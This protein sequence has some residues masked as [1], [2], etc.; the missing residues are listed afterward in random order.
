MRLRRAL[1][2]LL[3]VTLLASLPGVRIAPAQ[4][5]TKYDVKTESFNVKT[6]YGDVYV[7]VQR[8]VDPKNPKRVVK[9]PAILTYSPYS[10]L[11]VG[12]CGDRICDTNRWVP[13]GYARVWADVIGT[14]NSGGC[15][16][17]GGTA[18]KVSGYDL[19]EAIAKQPWSDGK[20]A[21]IGGSYEGTTAWATAVMHPPHLTTIVPEA[22]IARWYD[23]AFAG[24]IRYNDNNEAP[25]EGPAA[26]S[27]EGIDTPAG[28]DFG[29]AVPP[30]VDNQDP[31][32]AHKFQQHVTPCQQL[33]HTQQGYSQTPDYGKFW[34][35]RDYLLD[36]G[37]IHI[38]VMISAN[39]G[40]WNVKQIES[41]DMYHAIQNS[42]KKV[43]FMGN[44]WSGHGVPGGAYEKTV[45]AWMDHWL[46]GK[47]NG[48]Q[49]LP[50]VISQTSDL[51]QKYTWEQG[52]W[53][54]VTNVVLYA[55]ETPVTNPNDYAWK[56]LPTPWHKIKG[57]PQPQD[58]AKWPSANA[59]TESHEA[60]HSRTNHDWFWFE[61]PMLKHSIRVFGSPVVQV[62]LQTARSWVTV[63]PALFDE[64]IS[65]MQMEAGQMVSMDPVMLSAVT[66]GWLDSRYRDGLSKQVPLRVN[67]PFQL[68]VPL[69]P[70][71]WTFQK[72]HFLGLGLSTEIDEWSIPKPYP[73]PAEGAN[74]ANCTFVKIDWQHA[75]T[76]LILPV[77]G[78]VKN[79]M[80]LFDF[81][82]M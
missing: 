72:M 36:A 7:E 41:I 54:Q 2:P 3:A 12:L 43:L 60:H 6:K 18:E 76:R 16:D 22:A 39:W 52:A 14:G 19:V 51:N 45:N 5:A 35:Q 40:D 28:F 4:A 77:V 81:R 53:P 8:P 31:D 57:V 68:S 66:R 74:A 42:Q 29:L 15:W 9:A 47:D 48:V 24:G 82:G 33:E 65:R 63:T 1:V 78:T 13:R 23:Y 38:P 25:R 71:D 58:T 80:S 37:S 10:I 70:T 44:A 27:D 46:L 21:M 59:N 32:W 20:V 30:P 75:R 79:P 50:S 69:N 56:L 55:Q 62:Y 17:Y 11:W 49:N 34:T 26:P 67:K 64:D 61:T 73:C